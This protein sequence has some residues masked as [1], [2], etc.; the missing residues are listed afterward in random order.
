VDRTP[1]AVAVLFDD[2]QLTY[3]E[4]NARA[5]QLGHHLQ[6][7][8]VGPD[9][10][11]ALCVERSIEMVVGLL[12]ILKAGGA[13]VPLDPTYPSE[14]LAFLLEDTGAPVLLTQQRLLS[15]LPEHPAHRLCLDTDWEPIARERSDNPVN[16]AGPNHLAYVIYTSG[17]TGTPKGVMIPHRGLVNYLCWATQAYDAAGGQGAPVH[18]S[19]SFDLTVTGLFSPLLVG[20]KVVLTPEQSG[21][22]ALVTA[23]DQPEPF[24]LVKLTPAHLDVLQR[25]LPH[26]RAAN[27]TRALVIGG[28]ALSWETLAFFQTHAPA[29]RLIN[30]Y[31]P[32]ETVVGC[33]VY[34]VPAQASTTGPVP[35]GRPIA[36]TQ[37]YV[38]DTQQR[39]VPI[40]VP[41]ELYIGGDGV[42]RGYLHRPELTAERF[43]HDP[44][45][46]EP[47]A[48]LYRT[49][50]L[51]CFR[52]DGNLEFLGRL[53]HQVKLRGFRIELGEIESVL[54]QHAAVREAVVIAREDA[55][56]DKRLVAYLVAREAP[57]PGV[58]ALR[59]YLQ[60]KL[61][62]H[63]IPAAFVELPA[64]PLTPNGK[65]DRKALPDPATSIKPVAKS[66]APPRDDIEVKIADIFRSYLSLDALDIAASFF[67]LGGHS[68]MA[69]RV[70]RELNATFDL[71]LGVGA[72]FEKPSVQGLAEIVRN[73]GGTLGAAVIPLHK[74]LG[75]V[76]LFFI[77]GV[78]LYQA[79]ARNLGAKQ[80]SYGVWVPAEETFLQQAGTGGQQ[81]EEFAAEYVKTIRKH[82]PQGPYN[83]AGVSFGGLLAF[84]VARQLRMEGEA[85]PALV[86]LD[87]ILPEALTRNR[88]AWF[89]EKVDRVRKLGLR[90]AI[91]D[92]LGRM[93]NK[94]FSA[95]VAGVDERKKRDAELWRAINGPSC[96]R[97]LRAKP[98]YD[99]PTMIVRALFRPELVGFDVAP[100]LG[101]ADKLQSTVS[102]VDVPGD[103]LG[104][105]T[106]SETADVMRSYLES[107]QPRERRSI[108]P[109]LVRDGA[110]DGRA[111]E[112]PVE[113]ARSA[114]PARAT[115]PLRPLG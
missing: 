74:G 40:G 88:R 36:N 54:L 98:T 57:L 66:G 85:V 19:L 30:E 75:N 52:P 55:P 31:G 104:I 45:S 11:V 3:R 1:D 24:S 37:L 9:V 92:Q 87:S 82:T 111:V 79:L 10:L 76:P 65:V 38:L 78:H 49:G 44:F 18:S 56:G 103:H 71:E 33:C 43:L 35:I 97:Y 62:E 60:S 93:F 95:E 112:R 15:T 102:V 108:I 6:R 2:Q 114:E 13:Y 26:E 12:A 46:A 96:T 27:G 39:P 63:M 84:E 77:C 107:L 25:L 32:T 109:S 59:S 53:D 47:G 29:T 68:L 115:L 70:T 110:G 23:L 20:Q 99:G 100:E 91:D 22:E 105:L 17:S 72:I 80:S 73:R 61:P 48:R 42:A 86:L 64:L 94:A 28:E 51:C 101:W 7:L 50:D 14:R 90:G 113:V 4:L 21:I 67:D 69:A 8:G 83:L 5:N 106:L 81:F 89:T 58:S 34:E 41:G 16:A